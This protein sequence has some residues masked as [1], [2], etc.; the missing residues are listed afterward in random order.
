MFKR[1]GLNYSDETAEPETAFLFGL[2]LGAVVP[3]LMLAVG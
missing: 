3:L 1:N 2:A